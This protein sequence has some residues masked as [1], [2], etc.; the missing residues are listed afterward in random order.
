MINK[1][2][3]VPDQK[4][5]HDCTLLLGR[6]QEWNDTNLRWNVTD[7]GGVDK[8]HVPS[9]DIWLPDL[10]L[11]NKYVTITAVWSNRPRSLHT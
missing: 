7:Y 11:Y 2:D 6:F 4:N 3:C 8:L 1:T 9:S 10:V 5:S